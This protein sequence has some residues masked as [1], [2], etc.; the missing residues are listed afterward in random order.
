MQEIIWKNRS[1]HAVAN[2]KR[3]VGKDKTMQIEN[4]FLENID[5]PVNIVVILIVTDVNLIY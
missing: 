4:E 1:S 5:F 2:Q 3:K